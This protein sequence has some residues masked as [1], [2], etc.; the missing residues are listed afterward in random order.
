ME[1]SLSKKILFWS[2]T[3]LFPIL[4][5]ALI[6]IGLRVA[7][8]ND[9]KQELFIE[10]PSKE[11]Y[12]V[13]NP[14]FASR[15]FP[16]FTPQIAPAPFKKEKS[17]STFRVFVFGGS[18]T[19]GF[20]YNFYGSFSSR[21]EQKLIMETV[22]LKIEVV[23]LGMTAVNSYVI[24]D[25]S[26]RVVNYEPDAVIFY[27]GHNEYYG[28]FGVGSSQ[29]GIGRS[30]FLKRLIL[31]SKNLRLYQLL[32]GF[33]KPEEKESENRTMMA[34]VVKESNIE[35]N[36]EIY[37]AG[38]NQFKENMDKAISIFVD[39][40]IPVYVGTIASNLKDQAPL[41]DNKESLTEY[42]KG[43]TAFSNGEIEKAK[44]SFLRAK[45][46]DEIRFR[47]PSLMN[48]T[49]VELS[50]KYNIELVDIY[51]SSFDSSKSG[52]PDDSFFS[53]HLHPNWESNQVIGELF[54]EAIKNN[55]IKDYY[56]YNK[57]ST[58]PKINQFEKTFSETPIQRLKAGYPFNK[59]L[60]ERE[61]YAIFQRALN[62]SYNRSYIDSI[63]ATAWREQ[64]QVFFAVTDVINYEKFQK[65]TLGVVSHY[66]S[67]A[68][69]QIFNDDLLK[70][71]IN[72]AVNNREFDEMTALLLH[73]IINKE[74]RTDPYFLNSLA[75]L[76]LLNKDLDRARYWLK[77]SEQKEP[78][79]PILLYNY[80]RY[81]VLKGD[82][83]K[84]RSYFEAYVEASRNS[85]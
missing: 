56:Q 74:D 75:A 84:A 30:I 47:A 66:L 79:Q 15:Y 23:N 69:W 78:K 36:G 19:Q 55:Q 62:A 53:D 49:L 82:T 67:L 7:G 51:K 71:G 37:N 61:E 1:S 17:D 70:K 54:F 12:L 26:R 42:K 65:D 16:S 25:L 46:L 24:W 22:G 77:K 13:A 63:A 58:R 6:E 57:L 10:L 76:Y 18:S 83:S 40:E 85:K 68:Q 31:R 8:Y 73:L 50:E 60:T 35:L 5:F 41:G 14:K 80:A 27:A 20:P 3:L 81:Y 9:E 2:I 72:L 29:F 59:G 32:E 48:T 39:Q 45:E 28:S 21:L 64:R 43:E 38:V 4:L 33:L 52:I 44:T 11:E 34:K